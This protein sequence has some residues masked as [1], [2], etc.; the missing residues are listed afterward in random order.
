[1]LFKSAL[2]VLAWTVYPYAFTF[3]DGKVIIDE[4][5]GKSIS[6]SIKYNHSYPEIVDWDGTCTGKRGR[7]KI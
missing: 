1:M 7:Y 5:T 3:L 6:N 2:A 4:S